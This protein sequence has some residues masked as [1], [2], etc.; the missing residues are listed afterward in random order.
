MGAK[1][2]C[3]SMLPLQS[4]ITLVG[5]MDSDGN[6]KDEPDT[7]WK[8]AARK[9]SQDVKE[10][11]EGSKEEAARKVVDM[12]NKTKDFYVQHM[13]LENMYKVRLL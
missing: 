11:W 12:K 4:I 1:A 6:R 13:S 7:S 10:G 5:Q 2:Q 3:S 9:V 8:Q